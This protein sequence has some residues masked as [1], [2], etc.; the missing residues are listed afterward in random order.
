MSM[1]DICVFYCTIF[2]NQTDNLLFSIYVLSIFSPPTVLL[3][4]F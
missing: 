2:I 1:C 4:K 3:L